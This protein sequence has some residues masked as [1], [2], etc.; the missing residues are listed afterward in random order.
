MSGTRLFDT[1]PLYGHGLSEHRFGH[2]LRRKP[3]DSYVLSTKVGRWLE[4]HAPEQ[5][6][7]RPVARRPAT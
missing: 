3:R 6:R 1:A 2:V 7:P 5:P 4:P